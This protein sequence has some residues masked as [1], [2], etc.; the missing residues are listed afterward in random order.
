MSVTNGWH[1]NKSVSIAHIL[2][3]IIILAGAFVYLQDLKSNVEKNSQA[4]LNEAQAR[5][6]ADRK[7]EERMGRTDDRNKRQ[8]Q[9]IYDALVR[10]EKKVDEMRKK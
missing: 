9:Q 4:I 7:I 6:T 3:T 10:L 8:Y 2:T 5:I 1:L